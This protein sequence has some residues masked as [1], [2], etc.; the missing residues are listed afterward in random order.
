[1]KE[2]ICIGEVSGVGQFRVCVDQEHNERMEDGTKLYEHY[3]FD[4][5]AFW[6]DVALGDWCKA[7]IIYEDGKATTV[8]EKIEEPAAE[9]AAQ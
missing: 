9:E 3:V 8:I 7:S 6:K 1:M 2:V 4:R 5:W